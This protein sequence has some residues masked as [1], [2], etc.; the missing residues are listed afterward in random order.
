MPI[1]QLISIFMINYVRLKMGKIQTEKQQ[2]RPGRKN[3]DMVHVKKIISI[4]IVLRNNKK[5]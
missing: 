1:Y 5:E 2:G 4:L 3:Y